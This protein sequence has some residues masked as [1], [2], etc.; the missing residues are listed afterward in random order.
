MC[1]HTWNLTGYFALL[2]HMYIFHINK[3]NINKD[4]KDKRG[5]TLVTSMFNIINEIQLLS[6]Q[7]YCVYLLILVEKTVNS[8]I[9]ILAKENVSFSEQSD[10]PAENTLLKGR[11]L[12]AV[13]LPCSCWELR[14]KAST[15]QSSSS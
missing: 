7:N 11:R 14:K 9:A 1:T 13:M 8:V 4:I 15:S 12:I 3:R 10:A 5:A 6:D 2:V